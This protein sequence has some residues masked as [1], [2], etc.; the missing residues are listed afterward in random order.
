MGGILCGKALNQQL[1]NHQELFNTDNQPL[2]RGDPFGGHHLGGDPCSPAT[3]EGVAYLK[4]QKKQK[5][6]S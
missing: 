5:T 3:L 1:K 6:K 4:K 2:L